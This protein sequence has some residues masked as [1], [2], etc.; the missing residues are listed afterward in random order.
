[1]PTTYEPIATTTLGSSSAGITFSSIPQTYTD[2]VIVCVGTIATNGN[3][4]VVE[5]NGNTNQLGSFTLLGGNGSSAFSAR[6]NN[7][8]YVSAGWNVGFSNT[9][10]CTTTI[11]FFNYTNTTTFKATLARATNA[12]GSSLPGAELDAS[13]WRSTSAI[14]S[15]QVFTGGGGNLNAGFIATLYGIKAA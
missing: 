4:V 14:T 2:L 11:N 1:M 9:E 13:L 8:S 5:I 12:I 7:R 10:I 3:S 6:T 15:L